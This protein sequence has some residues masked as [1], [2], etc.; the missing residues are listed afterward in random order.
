MVT[1]VL[2]A[3]LSRIDDSDL[4]AALTAEVDLLRTHKDFGLVYERHLP[5]SV[6]LYSHPVRRGVRVELREGI[7]SEQIWKVLKVKDGIVTLV[8]SGPGRVSSRRLFSKP[9]RS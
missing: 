8:S 7:S 9:Q 5:E 6:I 2:D 4:R 1:N 3:F